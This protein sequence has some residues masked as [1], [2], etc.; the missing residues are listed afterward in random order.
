MILG[1]FNRRP[2]R[3]DVHQELLSSSDQWWLAS[4]EVGRLVL[5]SSDGGG[6]CPAKA[7]TIALG[8]ERPWVESLF[9][10]W[11]LRDGPGVIR[12]QH[13]GTWDF[14]E[15]EAY[16]V[17]CHSAESAQRLAEAHVGKVVPGLPQVL[18]TETLGAEAIGALWDLE[19]GFTGSYELNTRSCSHALD[20]LLPLIRFYRDWDEDEA[21]S[22]RLPPPDEYIL[23]TWPTTDPL[24]AHHLDPLR[25]AVP[26]EHTGHFSRP[27][28]VLGIDLHQRPKRKYF[29]I[30]LRNV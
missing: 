21:G 18:L 24:S 27:L 14:C 13:E 8:A 5:F 11:M 12:F 19:E 25:T 29:V 15:G 22:Q 3:V 17:A 10:A 4:D 16:F 28:P 6:A 30:S 7:P 20:E 26:R 9:I 23:D 1:L 2:K